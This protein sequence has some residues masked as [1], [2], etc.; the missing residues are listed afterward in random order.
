M[1]LIDESVPE[2]AN[3]NIKAINLDKNESN[4]P[5]KYKLEI[6]SLSALS[7]KGKKDKENNKSDFKL[8]SKIVNN[9]NFSFKG[10]KLNKSENYSKNDIDSNKE[11][12]FLNY[13]GN[14]KNYN[15]SNLIKGNLQNNTN[16]NINFNKNSF[17]ESEPQQ[18]TNLQYNNYNNENNINFSKI[19]NTNISI[20]MINFS[21][22]LD[23][24][25]NLSNNQTN[26]RKSRASRLF[27]T[28]GRFTGIKGK[29]SINAVCSLNIRA[30]EKYNI[31]LIRQFNSL[32]DKLNEER[33]KKAITEINES[34]R[35]NKSLRYY[36]LYK[37]KS[38]NMIKKNMGNLNHDYRFDIKD[39]YNNSFYNNTL[40]NFNSNNKKTYKDFSND[41][42]LNRINRH[43]IYSSPSN[44]SSNGIK[45]FKSKINKYSS[46]L[47]LPSNKIVH[48]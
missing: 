23:Y 46:K 17:K 41:N 29:I 43:N 34:N 36:E 44:I 18:N 3:K 2:K 31:N 40:N 47:V 1:I 13:T 42:S 33:D 10:I 45:L 4:I 12:K 5:K 38:N 19:E 16:K 26:R 9:I 14:M 39:N 21:N 48:F 30:E 20:P 25:N 28:G 22:T 37:D 27:G 7:F 6:S 35:D 32:V 11:N 8:C 24:K 15:S